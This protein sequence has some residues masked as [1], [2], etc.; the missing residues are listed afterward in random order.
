M[1]IMIAI[2][3]VALCALP[4]SFSPL[5]ALKKE[6]ELIER[7][8]LERIADL[9]F[10]EIKERLLKNE[11]SWDELAGSK[12]QKAPLPLPPFSFLIKGTGFRKVERQFKVSCPHEKEGPA[13][14]EYR[15]LLISLDLSLNKKAPYTFE[16]HLFAQRK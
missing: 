16:Y 5:K 11:I 8:E 13:G 10:A 7:L 14:A 2:A 12:K 3:L 6:F 4:F 1:E 15:H 9:S